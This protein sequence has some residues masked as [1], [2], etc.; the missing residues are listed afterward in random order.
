M[1]WLGKKTLKSCKRCWSTNII[2]KLKFLRCSRKK[3]MPKWST[4]RSETK[5]IQSCRGWSTRTVNLL[6]SWPSNSNRHRLTW[7]C[8]IM[9][10]RRW[11]DA[12]RRWKLMR[13]RWWDAT[14]S[15]S[16]R[17]WIR[18]RLPK[19]KW[20]PQETWSSRSLSKRNSRGEPN[21]NSKKILEMSFTL[22]R[23]NSRL[24]SVWGKNMRRR[25]DRR[26]S[27]RKPKINRFSWRL[28]GH[29][30]KRESSRS[31][32]WSWCRSLLRMRSSS[33]WIRTGDA[34]VKPNTKET[35]RNSGSKSWNCIGLRETKSCKRPKLREW[36][37]PEFNSWFKWRRLDCWQSTRPS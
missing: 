4:W 33:K 17:V 1:Q 12:L 32:R 7:S 3:L 29:S 14:P 22:K 25:I 27:F 2:F 20:R 24:K 10:N 18:S 6:K 34:C 31:L 30:R 19:M 26:G 36:K 35:S 28:N 9:K 8:L 16:N 23:V 5:W 13:M 37:R 11:L 15:N 21:S